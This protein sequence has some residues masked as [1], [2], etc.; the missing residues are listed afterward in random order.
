MFTYFKVK[1]RFACIISILY[2]KKKTKKKIIPGGLEIKKRVTFRTR[3]VL[4]DVV[5]DD[6]WHGQDEGHL[7]LHHG[8]VLD[9]VNAHALLRGKINVIILE[10]DLTY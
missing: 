4:L 10:V 9:A 1:I 2:K 5:H 3:V 8:E 7:V 6:H